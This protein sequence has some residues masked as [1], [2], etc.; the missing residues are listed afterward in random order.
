[1]AVLTGTVAVWGKWSGREV[2]RFSWWLALQ[3]SR[4][5][6]TFISPVPEQMVSS[7]YQSF[8]VLAFAEVAM[9]LCLAMVL[10]YIIIIIIIRVHFKVLQPLPYALGTLQCLGILQR[11]TN[12]IREYINQNTFEVSTSKGEGRR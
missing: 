4:I 5:R 9:V 6:S 12:F 1:M 3:S 11:K 8:F 10:I 2:A 7:K